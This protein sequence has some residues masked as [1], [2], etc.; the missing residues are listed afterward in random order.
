MAQTP[1]LLG[2][3]GPGS[4]IKEVSGPSQAQRPCQEEAFTAWKLVSGADAYP[5]KVRFTSST[6]N[7][8]YG[9]RR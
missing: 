7:G 1:S 3:F 6:Q 2:F 4:S 5:R 9:D 8:G